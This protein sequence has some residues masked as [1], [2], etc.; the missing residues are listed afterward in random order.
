MGASRWRVVIVA[1]SAFAV[2]AFAAVLVTLLVR[3]PGPRLSKDAEEIRGLI[4]QAAACSKED[5][6]SY[7]F[8]SILPGHARDQNLSLELARYAHDADHTWPPDIRY[9]ARRYVARDDPK[10]HLAALNGEVQRDGLISM[11]HSDSIRG[12]ECLAAYSHST[13]PFFPFGWT[14]PKEGPTANG[15]FTFGA[16]GLWTG[17]A[18]FS[19]IKAHGRWLIIGFRLPVKNRIIHLRADGLWKRVAAEKEAL[20]LRGR[21]RVLV[22][23]GPKGSIHAWRQEIDFALL[24]KEI[25]RRARQA[26]PDAEGRPTLWL[27]IIPH[28]TVCYKSIARILSLCIKTRITRTSIAIYD[29]DLRIDLPGATRSDGARRGRVPIR[30]SL[31]DEP[32]GSVLEQPYCKPGTRVSVSLAGDR[33]GD[34]DELERKLRKRKESGGGLTVVVHADR[35]VPAQWVFDTLQVCE[36]AEVAF[37]LALPGAAAGAP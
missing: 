16:D 11:I 1:G 22:H 6:E 33:C 13:E 19:A 25:H 21:R 18:D 15:W 10:A 26:R 36:E 27:A 17:R 34:L 14:V 23:L 9:I 4:P 3:S 24:S 2:G 5:W 32:A 31:D 12:F 35:H 29:R 20:E 30:L 28:P 7:G 8:G 37:R